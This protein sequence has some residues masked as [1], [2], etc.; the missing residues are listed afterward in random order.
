MDSTRPASARRSAFTLIELL[1]V[2]SIIAVL[3]GMLLPAVSSVREAARAT[4]CASNLRSLQMAHIAYAEQWE[5]Y[6][7]PNFLGDWAVAVGWD[8]NVDLLSLYTE[9]RIATG[10]GAKLRRSQLCPVADNHQVATT[11]S[12]SLS[13][14]MNI[15]DHYKSSFPG[16]VFPATYIGAYRTKRGKMPTIMAFA[17]CLGN[18]LD[19][20]Y[21]ADYWTGTVPAPE[22]YTISGKP[23]AIAYRHRGRANVV[24]YDGHTESQPVAALACVM[25]TPSTRPWY[26]W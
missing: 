11:W 9:D 10:D 16:G 7:A 2:I 4:Q 17:D 13:W 19:A 18:M 24:M 22:G 21:G 26:G 20:R 14:G 3:A 23:G 6:F 5:G 12:S 25:G 15:A 1:V 8:H